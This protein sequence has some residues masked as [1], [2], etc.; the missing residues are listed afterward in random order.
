MPRKKPEAK[1]YMNDRE[2]RLSGL[3]TG[4]IAKNYLMPMVMQYKSIKK[5]VP[6]ASM[7]RELAEVMLII[8][9]KNLGSP[10]FRRYSPDWK[11]EM[12]GR[13]V[14]HL[15]K[16]SH[17]FDPAKCAEGKD[18]PY[19]YFA[20]IANMAFVQSL[21][22]LK[23]HSEHTVIINHDVLYDDVDIMKEIGDLKSL[24]FDDVKYKQMLEWIRTRSAQIVEW[25]PLSVRIDGAEI[26]LPLI[27]FSVSEDLIP[28]MSGFDAESN[29]VRIDMTHTHKW[30]RDFAESNDTEGMVRIISHRK[31][32]FIHE[33]FAYCKKDKDDNQDGQNI[34]IGL[35]MNS[36]QI[37]NL[38][39]GMSL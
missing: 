11:E 20:M 9:E 35:G 29:S 38:D 7:P 34:D 1:V 22:K 39:W 28:K 3:R 8:I 6:K 13:A 23:T 19:N 14:E 37:S 31:E 10:S 2:R 24:K 21:K 5:K 4:K 30:F 27:W 18:D 16:Y 36:P 33:V 25:N 12:R 17:N 26:G 15:L 32:E